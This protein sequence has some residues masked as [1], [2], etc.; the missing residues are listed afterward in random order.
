MATERGRGRRAALYFC[1]V[2]CFAAAG[3]G[4]P[5]DGWIDG[6]QLDRLGCTMF[7]VEENGQADVTAK[8]TSIL[9][10]PVELSEGQAVE[11]NGQPLTGPDARLEYTATI[12]RADTYLITA[13]EPTRGVQDTTVKPPAAFAITSPSEG[14]E[15]SLSGFTV[16]WSNA[17]PD[18]HV[19][20]RV[21]QDIFGQQRAFV[22]D[23]L[24]DG[25]SFTL[26]AEDLGEFQQGADLDIT[27]RR[28]RQ[29]S[30][31]NGFN[32]GQVSVARS[33]TVQCV[34]AP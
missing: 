5:T 33:Q 19:L 21:S 29:V 32:S 8:I 4:C 25:G 30:A 22:S 20:V 27:V 10:L 28:I 6:T 23:M 26:T 1:A 24:T 3:G 14:G 13:I 7:I 31:I 15:A 18:L 17:N 11:V 34:P 9:G 16:T 2:A 12:P